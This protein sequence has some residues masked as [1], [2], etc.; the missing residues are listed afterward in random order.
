MAPP[1]LPGVPTA[2]ALLAARSRATTWATPS[3]ASAA[4]A[5]WPA[6]T[7]D[8]PLL[9]DSPEAPLPIHG[10]KVNAWPCFGLTRGQTAVLS[11]LVASNDSIGPTRVGRACAPLR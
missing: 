9:N 5:S 6:T 1:P 3:A 11:G 2:I 8:S 7:A 4:T 10:F